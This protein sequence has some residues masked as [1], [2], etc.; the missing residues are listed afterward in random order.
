MNFLKTATTG[1]SAKVTTSY[2]YG[3]NP[4]MTPSSPL[5]ALHCFYIPLHALLRE[6]SIAPLLQNRICSAATS[7]NTPNLGRNAKFP[8][9]AVETLGWYTDVP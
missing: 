1:C 5:I 3:R 6:R 9:S 2:L 4:G 7:V 8:T